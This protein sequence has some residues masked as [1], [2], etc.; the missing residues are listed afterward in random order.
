MKLLQYSGPFSKGQ[1]VLVPPDD[2]SRYVHIGLQVPYKWKLEYL[3]KQGVD[4][5]IS[6][7]NGDEK[8]SY[9]I[10]HRGILEFDGLSDFY[11]QITFNRSL[12]M[13]TIV[14]IIYKDVVN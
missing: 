1:T 4:P 13:E 2:D 5:D 10:N 9:Y 14:D 6:I 8:F 12:P 7:Y 11:Y 3:P